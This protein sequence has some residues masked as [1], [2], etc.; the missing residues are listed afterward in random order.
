MAK[1]DKDTPPNIKKKRARKRKIEDF[2]LPIKNIEIIAQ[3]L[4]KK[5]DA[6]AR[7]RKYAPAKEVL[8]L[9]A[10]GTLLAA[11][12]VMP[13][14]SEGLKYFIHDDLRWSEKDKKEWKKYNHAYLAKTIK[15]L[16]RQK[17]VEIEEEGNLQMVK[18]TNR[19]RKRVL[20]Y[21][22]EELEIKRPKMWNGKWYFVTYDIPKGKTWERNIFRDYLKKLEFYRFHESL[23]IHAYPCEDEIEFLREYL[24]LGKHVKLLV[25]NKIENDKPFR[26][27]FG[28]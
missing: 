9:L 12:L 6:E 15:R 2:N 13:G 11:S 22:L 14:L 28:I 16:E 17:L 4:K 18:I 19:G 10:G 27:Y 3:S 1:K 7:E 21:A 20:K 8:T 26:E 5:L 23:Y 25:V 24:G